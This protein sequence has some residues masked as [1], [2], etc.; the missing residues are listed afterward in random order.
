MADEKKQTVE[1]VIDLQG[2]QTITGDF[3]KGYVHGDAAFNRPLEG[4]YDIENDAMTPSMVCMAERVGLFPAE[5]AL[6]AWFAPSPQFP[7]PTTPDDLKPADMAYVVKLIKYLQTA[8][9]EADDAKVVEQERGT[10]LSLEAVRRFFATDAGNPAW[11]NALIESYQY[12]DRKRR[13][14]EAVKSCPF[15]EKRRSLMSAFSKEF[16]QY[17]FCSV[18]MFLKERLTG[19]DMVEFLHTI[20]LERKEFC[21]SSPLKRKRF[22]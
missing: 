14:I 8:K 9:K 21:V 19:A 20:E 17:V 18:C 10:R 15:C 6:Y 2:G 3:T 11:R 5:Y 13:A 1:Q 7:Q 12:T 16:S 22:E 4:S